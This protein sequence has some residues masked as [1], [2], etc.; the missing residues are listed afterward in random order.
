MSPIPPEGCSQCRDAQLPGGS[1]GHRPAWLE[2]G[3]RPAGAPEGGSGRAGLREVPSG[4]LPGVA[5]GGRTGAAAAG[6]AGQKVGPADRQ[7]VPGGE[8]SSPPLSCGEWAIT[9]G[10]LNIMS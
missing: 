10:L 8:I 2:G 3:G 6:E 5:G 1:A 7:G 9:D 4:Q